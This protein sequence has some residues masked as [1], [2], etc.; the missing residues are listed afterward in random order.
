MGL[1]SFIGSLFGSGAQKKGIN[2]A[3]DAQMQYL[4]KA[5]DT[6]NAQYQQSR[7]DFMPYMDF[8]KGALGPLGD[9]LGMNG[10]DAAGK[11][12]AALK[13]SPLFTSLFNTGQ[14]ATL[15]NASATGGIRGGNTEGALYDLGSNT[16]AQVIQQQISNLFGATGVG[17][18]ATG[19]TAQLGAHNADMVSKLFGD[20]GD[21]LASKYLAKAG[22]NAKNWNNV[23]GFLDQ[24]A[25]AF[26]PMA[27]LPAGLSSAVG[28]LF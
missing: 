26:L 9:L 16:L 1:F 7:S 28:Q 14:E 24:A 3:S 13:S 18:G 20:Q 8:G 27:G 22:I 17:E 19:S 25:S 23:G 4:N 21:T 2:K 11:A 15:Q 5:I 12:I 10:S 6:E